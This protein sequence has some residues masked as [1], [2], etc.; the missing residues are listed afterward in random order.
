MILS[1]CNMKHCCAMKVQS[2]QIFQ[3]MVFMSFITTQTLIYT[4][5][6]TTPSWL[7]CNHEV[8]MIYCT[9]FECS[10]SAKPCSDCGLCCG[11][12][13]VSMNLVMLT[14][15]LGPDDNKCLCHQPKFFRLLLRAPFT[16]KVIVLRANPATWLYGSPPAPLTVIT[17]ELEPALPSPGSGLIT[18]RKR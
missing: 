16:L 4:N 7:W 10:E 14:V 12:A 1:N 11:Q 13:N 5:T 17:D 3:K 6:K 15:E 9:F 8:L 18:V 2:K